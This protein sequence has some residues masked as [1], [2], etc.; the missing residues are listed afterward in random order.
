MNGYGY[1]QNRQNNKPAC[2]LSVLV[3]CLPPNTRIYLPRGQT[4]SLA[5]LRSVSALVV[6]AG[7]RR[8][9]GFFHFT[10]FS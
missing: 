9:W 10:H 7:V 8:L 2:I 4:Q 1:D 3:V 6:R 5:P